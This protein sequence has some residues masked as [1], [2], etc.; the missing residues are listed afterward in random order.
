MKATRKFCGLDFT[1][2][3]SAGTEARWRRGK[4]EVFQHAHGRWVAA[5]PGASAVAD[6]PEPAVKLLIARVASAAKDLDLEGK[7]K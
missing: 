1:S 2:S 4:V 6:E 7:A 3:P 5:A